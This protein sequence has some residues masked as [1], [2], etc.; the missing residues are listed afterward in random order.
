MQL[1]YEAVTLVAGDLMNRHHVVYS[2]ITHNHPIAE[3][4]DLPRTWDFW[5]LFDLPML[6]LS[7][8]LFVLCLPGW[9][10]STG[11]TAEIEYAKS[12]NI[13]IV[14]MEPSAFSCLAPFDL[15]N[16]S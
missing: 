4:T 7:E 6:D 1:R 10:K 12:K 16:D 2:P 9:K 5:K 11:V 13:P 3:R 15:M 14:Y 8:S